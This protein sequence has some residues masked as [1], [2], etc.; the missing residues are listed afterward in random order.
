MP[1]NKLVLGLNSLAVNEKKVEISRRVFVLG[2]GKNGISL[3]SKLI[4]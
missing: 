2:F 1:A 4:I 3:A